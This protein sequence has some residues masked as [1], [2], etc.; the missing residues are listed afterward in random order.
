MESGKR[1]LVDHLEV[2]VVVEDG[3]KNSDAWSNPI[4]FNRRQ[5]AYL[6]AGSGYNSCTPTR[7]FLDSLIGGMPRPWRLIV[8]NNTRDQIIFHVFQVIYLLSLNSYMYRLVI[9]HNQSTK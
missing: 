4:S 5:I 6:K 9:Y 7:V 2:I 3:G 8:A 1:I